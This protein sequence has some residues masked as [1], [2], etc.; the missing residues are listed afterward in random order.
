MS[1]AESD[2]LKREEAHPPK[3]DNAVKLSKKASTDEERMI[4]A[5][6]AI[7]CANIRLRVR[8]LLEEVAAKT[9]VNRIGG[10]A[11]E[12]GELKLRRTRS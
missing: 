4:A 12:A 6:R 1:K 3:E 10:A 7:P 11:G 8:Q 9:A 2:D 5:Y